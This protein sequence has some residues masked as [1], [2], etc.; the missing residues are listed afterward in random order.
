MSEIHLPH[1][2]GNDAPL[3]AIQEKLQKTEAF[4]K[5]AA[6]FQQLG[7]PTRLRIFWLLCHYRACVTNIAA[8]LQMSNPAV[9][10]HLRPLKASGLIVSQRAGR[11]VYYTAADTVQAQLLHRMLEQVMEIAC[12]SL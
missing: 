4:Q 2:H 9:S 1:D 12:P 10:H 8:L 3:A 7:D 11:E 5:T 6:L